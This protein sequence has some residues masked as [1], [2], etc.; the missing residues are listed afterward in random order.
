MRLARLSIV[1][2]ALASTPAFAQGVTLEDLAR[3]VEAL[4]RENAELKAEVAS[5]RASE[6]PP[7]APAP[8][9]SEPPP[10]SYGRSAEPDRERAAPD[11]LW[12]SAYVGIHAGYA[13]LRS[14]LHRVEVP[15]IPIIRSD[16][17]GFAFGAQL[18]RRWQDGNV[19]IGAEL[20]ADFPKIA[21][22]HVD[23]FSPGDSVYQLDLEARG[24]VKGQIGFASGPWLA[25]GT[26]GLEHAAFHRG[27]VPGFA[28]CNPICRP[29]LPTGPVRFERRYYTG[30]LLG[31]GAGYA[32]GEDL[33]LEVE[34]TRTTYGT[35]TTLVGDNHPRSSLGVSLRLNQAIR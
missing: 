24:R 32:L 9:A 7:T 5:L 30:F 18:G 31:L 12:D 2:A 29:F 14:S 33:R 22:Q 26:A 23:V 21:N 35:P 15:I 3:R 17:D 16:S 19:V 8:Y 1:A 20:E 10:P 4:E 6:A 13:S 11:E 25:Y 27:L 28:F 34:A